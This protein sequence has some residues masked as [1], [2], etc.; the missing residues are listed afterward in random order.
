MSK[1]TVFA[2]AVLLAPA[3]FAAPA[4]STSQ[5]TIVIVFKDGHRQT[6][7]LADIAHI[8]FS[9][10]AAAAV[11]PAPITA[12]PARGEFVGRWIVGDGDGNT[13]AITLKEDGTAVRSLHPVHG[14]WALV[15][16]EARIH[17]NDGA[18]DAIRKVGSHFEKRAFGSNK[19]FDDTPDNVTDARNTN[20]KPI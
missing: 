17:W 2:L 20:P 9:G 15:N 4:R 10:A 5:Q 8:E 7:N 6:F 11:A 1:L 18:Q 19:S 12:L 13:F 16:G 14:A 3:A